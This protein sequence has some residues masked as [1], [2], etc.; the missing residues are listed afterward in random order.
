MNHLHSVVETTASQY[1][2]P[3]P[4]TTRQ[5][6][7]RNAHVTVALVL[8]DVCLPNSSA[9]TQNR[10]KRGN[11][12]RPLAR[13]TVRDNVIV[14]PEDIFAR[15]GGFYRK[16]GKMWKEVCSMYPQ[17]RK[18]RVRSG[19]CWKH[20]KQLEQHLQYASNATQV[21]TMVNTGEVAQRLSQYQ[22]Y[23]QQLYQIHSVFNSRVYRCLQQRQQASPTQLTQLTHQVTPPQQPLGLR[24]HN[25]MSL[26]F[27]GSTRSQKP[28]LK[29]F[30]PSQVSPPCK[31]DSS[32]MS[33]PRQSQPFLEREI[34]E[35]P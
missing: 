2:S 13:L 18:I 1:V 27:Q 33:T 19:C 30:M 32:T 10:G 5:R 25:E 3:Q 15:L 9:N 7:V 24:F 20:G 26:S 34:V 21:D 11:V 17:C 8:D 4:S 29:F 22:Q 23:Q 16:S 35:Y 28:Q 6:H 12:Q 14:H 31:V